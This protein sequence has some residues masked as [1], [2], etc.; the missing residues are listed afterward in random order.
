M[1]KELNDWRCKPGKY[2]GEGYSKLKKL[3][4][5]FCEVECGW[6]VEGTAKRPEH[7]K[8]SDQGAVL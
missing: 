6:H 3:K 1:I 8:Q 5:Q 7:M 4:V 2:P